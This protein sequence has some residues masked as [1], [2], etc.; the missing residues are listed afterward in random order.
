MAGVAETAPSLD[1]VQDSSLSNSSIS[2]RACWS[3]DFSA[4]P[5]PMESCA[6]P[7][8]G[9]YWSF[10]LVTMLQAS[11]QAV[12]FK[13]GRYFGEGQGTILNPRSTDFDNN[14]GHVVGEGTVPPRSYAVKDCPLHFRQWQRRRFVNQVFQTLHAE[15]VIG[16]VKNLDESIRVEN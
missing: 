2:D 7:K 13:V 10:N 3:P 16:T 4:A 15:H 14:E 6:S 11:A 12:D 5:I 8:L 9:W 1:R